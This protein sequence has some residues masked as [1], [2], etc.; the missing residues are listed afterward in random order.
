MV[1]WDFLDDDNDPYDDVQYGHG[2]GEARDST[3]EANNR[4]DRTT[5]PSWPRC[6]NCMSVHMRV[7]DSFVAD[8]NRFAQAVDLRGRQR[9]A[10][11]AVGARHAQQLQPR[12]RRR[13]LRLRPRRDD[14]VSAA[15]EAAQ[16]NN[17][18]S[19]PHTILVNSVTQYDEAITPN[20]RSYLQFN[21]CTNF[22]SK[23]TVAIPSVSCSS[24]AVGRA[25]GMAGL[26][27]SAAT[28]AVRATTASPIPPASG[29]R[30]AVPDHAQRGA[31]ADGHR[32]RGRRGAGRRRG[33]RSDP[34]LPCPAPGCTDPYLRPPA[35]WPR[36]R[37]S[38]RWPDQELPGARGPRPVLRLRA[39]EHGAAR[40]TRRRR[41]RAPARGRAHLARVVPAGG[42]GARRRSRCGAPSSLAASRT[43]CRVLRGAGGL[44]ERRRPRPPAGDFQPVPSAALRRHHASARAG[45]TACS[46]TWTWRR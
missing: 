33:L 29:E 13:E 15:D 17:Q 18:P 24:D 20:S 11:G 19:L 34:E 43:R 12:A 25:S 46:A 9:R 42:S 5:R 41:R 16:H 38:R 10:G 23:I 1:G 2:T 39:G 4:V 28:N 3:A 21:G 22:N 45:S 7:G 35:L 8:V 36:G 6:P 31:P 44:P 37:S 30:R 27:I 26:I 40:S 14:V 32:H